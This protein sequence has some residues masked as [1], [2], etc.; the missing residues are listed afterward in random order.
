[1]SNLAQVSATNERYA[2]AVE[3][4]LTAPK[5]AITGIPIPLAVADIV[6]GIT[7]SRFAHLNSESL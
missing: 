3:A 4:R 5:D 7:E 2:F 1:M 6:Q